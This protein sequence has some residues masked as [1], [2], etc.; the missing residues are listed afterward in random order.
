[1]ANRGQSQYLRLFSGATTYK[2]WQ[3]Y[4]VNQTVT[5]DSQQ[6][7]YYPFVTDGFI[8]GNT[9]T[10]IGSN[11]EVPATTEAVDLFTAALT[12]NWLCEVRFYEFPT[13]LSQNQPQSGQLLIGTLVGEVVNVKGTFTLLTIDLGS[14]LAP[15]GAQVP[16]RKYTN[17]L[18]GA[19][20]RL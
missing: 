18:I 20:L 15:V 9:G 8:G 4:Y 14:S 12:N 19:P 7:A 2:R 10:Q 13:Q 5:W 6:W 16:P 11:I 17:T 1:M 3:N